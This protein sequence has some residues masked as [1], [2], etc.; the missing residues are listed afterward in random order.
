MCDSG[1]GSKEG[2]P[3]LLWQICLA[4]PL[5]SPTFMAMLPGP[6]EVV[7]VS[8]LAVGFSSMP[9]LL[10]LGHKSPGQG[11]DK[12]NVSS[13]CPKDLRPRGEQS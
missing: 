9:R 12:Q 10:Q 4:T 11:Q 6:I 2:H 13:P 1:S 8:A 3:P 7:I 5:P